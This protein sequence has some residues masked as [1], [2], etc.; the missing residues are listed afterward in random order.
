VSVASTKPSAAEEASKTGFSPGAAMIRFYQKYISDLRFG[1]CRFGPSCSQYGIEA[2]ESHGFLKG[3]VLTA[4]RLVRCNSSAV[5]YYTR[6]SGGRLTDPVDGPPAVR[7]SPEVPRWLLPVP[8]DPPFPIRAVEAQPLSLDLMHRKSVSDLMEYAAFADAL[9]KQGDC[10]R[11]ETEYKRVAF[12]ANA[13]EVG[14]WALIKTGN[15]YYRWKRWGESTR[16]FG[17]AASLST[18]DADKNVAYFMAA[19]S[20][21]NDGKYE[22]SSKILERCAFGGREVPGQR[23]AVHDPD[24]QDA[25]GGAQ[26]IGAEKVQLLSGLCLMV[27]GDWEASKGR[28]ANIVTDYPNSPNRNQALYLQWKA[29]EGA[30]TVPQKHPNLAAGLSVVIPGL[31]QTYSGRYFDGFRHF[32]IDG[33]L[34]ITVYQLFKEEHYAAGYLVA[35]FTLPFY[36]GNVVGAKRSAESY[37]ASKRAEYVSQV[38]EGA[39]AE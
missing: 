16:S 10:A 31:G 34:I 6:G 33:L 15:C 32:V 1:H 2:I 4:D 3:T 36:I 24:P 38:I 29:E 35:G 25:G 39:G 21:F 9:T 37:N 23:D 26:E 8:S 12:L 30:A 13:G 28:F 5:H 20:Y 11:A 22:E 7:Q 17:E 27:S 19:A 18:T 14:R